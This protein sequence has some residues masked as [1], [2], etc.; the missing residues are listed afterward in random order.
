M[1]V[2]GKPGASTIN[3]ATCEG[4]QTH[5]MA[6]VTKSETLKNTHKCK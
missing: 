4:L 2:L 3:K 1:C 5:C 6:R